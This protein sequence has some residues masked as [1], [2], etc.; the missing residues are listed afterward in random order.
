MEP[1]QRSFEET[2]PHL[3]EFKSF[4]DLLNKESERGA[5]LI[6]AAMIDDLLGRCISAF[7]LDHRDTQ[8]LIEGFNAPL[9]TLSARTLVAF[10]LGL[11]SESEYNDCETIRKIR[12]EFAH[13]VPASFK[14]QRVADLCGNLKLCAG[15]YGDVHVDARGRYTTAAVGVVLN[16]TNRPHYAANRR[17]TYSGWPY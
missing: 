17:L 2:H 3:R 9:G 11:L 1:S 5:V 7:L 15:D 13:N 12:N 4:L 6:A 10:T 8:R 14:D 16:L